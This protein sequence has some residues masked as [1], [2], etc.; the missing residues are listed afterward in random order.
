[1]ALMNGS[2]PYKA[3]QLATFAIMRNHVKTLY[4]YLI[5]FALLLAAI[6]SYSYGH[7]TGLFLFIILGLAFEAAFWF[8]LFLNKKKGDN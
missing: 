5:I 6:A 4:R 7:T 3:L 2:M 8:K 1:M